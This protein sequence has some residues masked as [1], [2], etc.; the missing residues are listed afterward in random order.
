VKSSG[1]QLIRA[2]RELLQCFD[3]E[4][5]LDRVRIYTGRH[6]LARVMG[7]LTGGSAIALGYHVFV[8]GRV[9]LPMLAHELTHVCQYRRWG[10]IRYYARG[11][12][13]Q[14]ILRT[15]C[16]RDVYHWS[17]TPGKSFGDYG[18][19]QQGQIVEDCFNPYSR[20]QVEASRISPFTP[21]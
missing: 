8:P 10:V 14:V 15:I 2:E 12:W 16:G 21:R 9:R 18:M 4:I 11:F 5:S 7:W 3:R 20:R 13:N 17:P 19:E 6:R 1:R